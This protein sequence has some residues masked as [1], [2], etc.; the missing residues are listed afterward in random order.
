MVVRAV[1]V[2]MGSYA[3]LFGFSLGRTPIQAAI[4][5][6]QR[7]SNGEEIRVIA[8]RKLAKTSDPAS[9]QID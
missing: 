8:Y 1:L 6:A 9:S 3:W 2:D 4:G 5:T 7:C